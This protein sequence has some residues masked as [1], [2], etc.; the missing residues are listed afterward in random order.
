MAL[1]AW[2]CFQILSEG[3]SKLL[4]TQVL[5]YADSPI[6]PLLLSDRCRGATNNAGQIAQSF[7]ISE[8]VVVSWSCG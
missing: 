8:N 3:D 1:K 6:A 7:P 4:D 5:Q 2:T